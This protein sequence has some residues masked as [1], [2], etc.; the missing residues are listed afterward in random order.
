MD[1]AVM[2]PE[3]LMLTTSDA[4]A[5]PRSPVV[6]SGGNGDDTLNGGGGADTL[7]GYAGND[8]LSGRKGGD[9][10]IGGIGADSLF[11]GAGG[12]LLMAEQGLAVSR[13]GIMVKPAGL[14]NGS[15]E[16]AL[17]VDG[18]FSRAANPDIELATTRPHVTI[19]ATGDGSVD[20]Y[21][22]TVTVAGSTGTFDIDGAYPGFDAWLRLMDASGGVLAFNDDALTDAGSM[23]AY[24]SFS[25][26][27]FITY[28]FA[29]AGTYVIAV[30]AYPNL[31]SVP[32]GAAYDLQIS[33]DH[34]TDRGAAG[35]DF[36]N[37][38]GGADTLIGGAGDDNLRGGPGNDSIAGSGGDDHLNGGD[39][40]DKLAGGGGGDFMRGGPGSDLMLAGTGRDRLSGGA[41]ADTLRGGAGSDRLAGGLDDDRVAGGGGAD[42][43]H[44]GQ[45]ADRL[46]AGAGNDLL[47][48]GGG[49]DRLFG[50][51]G[52]DQLIG[53]PGKDSL[54]GGAG[55]DVFIFRKAADSPAGSGH[56]RIT[57]FS[58]D[59]DHI[60]LTA[61]DA[62]PGL[63]GDDAFTFIDEAH[64]SH[65]A[66]ELRYY[67][68]SHATIVA[69]DVD[70]D[71]HADLQIALAGNLTLSSG[72]FML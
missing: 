58:P 64:F 8:R 32:Q 9:L 34:G 67:H 15:L 6:A 23:E 61:I 55:E 44:G 46:S 30:G 65:H 69:G 57:D 7:Q 62:D 43:L 42:S 20:Y 52:A 35:P 40:S 47:Y 4:Q 1:G 70:G 26:D 11:G 51:S 3:S 27:S 60:D 63:A 39:G 71:R 13:G 37:G 41:G 48:G 33:L 28:T 14:W 66:G 50:G 19:E 45:G 24:P 5:L 10:L 12:D 49:G 16:A 21:A 53:G 18:A 56:D 72:D 29:N 17:G 22:F 54:T 59:S 25:R 68:T 36:A 2:V 38:G 31:E